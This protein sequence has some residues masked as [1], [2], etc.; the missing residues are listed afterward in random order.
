MMM[1]SEVH[2]PS[3][4]RALLGQNE[5][6]MRP[7]KLFLGGITRNTTTKQLRDHFSQY[8][9]VLDCVAMRQPDGRPRGFGYVT[10]D[11]PEAARRCVMEPQIIDNR[12]IDVKAAVPEGSGSNK[13]MS[14]DYAESQCDWEAASM[15]QPWWTSSIFRGGATMDCVDLLSRHSSCSATPSDT[16]RQSELGAYAPFPH[17]M[18]N[19]Y[20]ALDACQ[21]AL[22]AQAPEFV[23]PILPS[24]VQHQPPERTPTGRSPLGEIT[25]VTQVDLAGKKDVGFGKLG[26]APCT[27]ILK[28][29]SVATNI[30]AGTIAP[31]GAMG[32]ETNGGH[33]DS[34]GFY[35]DDFATAESCVSQDDESLMDS[36][37]SVRTAYSLP[38]APPTP[39]SARFD[40]ELPSRGSALHAQGTCKRCNFYAKGRCQNGKDC[41]FCHFPHEKRKATRQEKRERRASRLTDGSADEGEQYHA[42]DMPFDAHTTLLEWMTGTQ[43][44]DVSFACGDMLAMEAA[45]ASFAPPPGL[46]MSGVAAGGE[47]WQP[48]EEITPGQSP[49][50][51]MQPSLT[52]P[53]PL[54]S[55]ASK[56]CVLSTMPLC[57]SVAGTPS[58]V[59][60]NAQV[61]ATTPTATSVGWSASMGNSVTHTSAAVTSAT[62][63]ISTQTDDEFFCLSCGTTCAGHKDSKPKWTREE[64]LKF[65]SAVKLEDA[66]AFRIRTEV[67][68]PAVVEEVS[69]GQ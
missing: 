4:L 5:S 11:S 38:T 13:S 1:D 12:I 17:E 40:G 7:T 36:E 46:D 42:A 51:F 65:R 49:A 39:S 10:L 55:T 43:D 26:S 68:T 34:L 58:S 22:S 57:S 18:L 60:S 50:H 45:R 52:L 19:S 61:F 48:D 14:S 56:D 24:T 32:Q 66:P 31:N 53:V 47:A 62:Q 29:W 30:S 64:L 28:P 33:V 2:R 67:A 69:T 25:N 35:I 63:T 44:Q 8:G 9:R 37:Q 15:P 21:Q 20:T 59:T 6:G 54:P 41:T 27:D 3:P 16:P 23:P